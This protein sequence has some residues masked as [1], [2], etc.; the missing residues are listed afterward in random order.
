MRNYEKPI[1]EIQEFEIG[2]IMTS[3][4]IDGNNDEIELE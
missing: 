2:D 4:V 1:M 3:N